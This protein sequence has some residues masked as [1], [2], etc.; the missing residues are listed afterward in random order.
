MDNPGFHHYRMGETV[1]T[2]LFDG[3]VDV[4]LD[5][6]VGLP[7][8][9]VLR[10]QRQAF[11]PEPSRLPVTCFVIRR[12]GSTILVDAGGDAAVDPGLGL[13][14]S[15]MLAARIDPAD[16]TTVLLTHLH[17]DHYAGLLYPDGTAA[18]P[19]AELVLHANEVAF[20]L[21][22]SDLAA[23]PPEQRAG[24]DAVRRAVAPYRD[25]LR[26]VSHG[27]VLPGVDAVPLP[28]HT[29]G[30]TGWRV[31]DGGRQLL[32]W[33]DIVHFPAVQFSHPEVSLSYDAD[34]AQSAATRAA[35]FREA[36]S[37]GFLIA[38]AHIDFPG[39][40]FVA[41]EGDTTRWVPAP[42]AATAAA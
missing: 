4:A 7:L 24:V 13:R 39:L 6:L 32:F 9:T 38:G 33:G 11:Q 41:S 29:P 26:I 15:A 12:P 31:S 19:N 36:A 25:R 16:V 5:E 2:A 34:P 18:F 28:G 14:Q 20:R 40:G 27:E 23:M 10:L 1:V 3:F 22:P 35:V 37:G 8:A 30:H 21:E 17:S 42:Y